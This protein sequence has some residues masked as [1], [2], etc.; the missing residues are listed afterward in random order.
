[1]RIGIG[2]LWQETNTL[3][4]CPTTR[5]D[6]EAMG[7][8]HGTEMIDDMA[9][10]NE[11]GG[12]IQS[13]RRWHP[14][15]EPIGLV[16]FSAWPSGIITCDA[17]NWMRC[18]LMKQLQS[19]MPL[20][21]V[22]LALHGSM[23]AEGHPDVEGDILEAVRQVIGNRIPLVATL[24]L[25]AQL[26]PAMLAATN[27]LVTY[28]SMPHIDIF[29]TGQRGTEVMRRILMEAVD[30]V[31]AYQRVPVVLPAERSNTE[32]D[33]GAASQRKRR[34]VE[35]E[36]S[37]GVLT[38]GVTVVQPWMDVPELCSAVVVTTDGNED[39]AAAHCAELATT[40]WDT[41]Y[42]YVPELVSVSHAVQRAHQN[43]ENGLSVLSDAAD[44]TTSGA[45]GDSVW[46]LEE[47]L[48]YEWKRPAIVTVVD[49]QTVERASGLDVS[50]QHEFTLG[51]KRDTRFGKSIANS[52]LINRRFQARFSMSGH[53]G[54]NLAIDMGPAV[55]LRR[56]NVYV[57]V[58]SKTGPHFAPELFRAAEMDPFQASLL[59][60]KSPCGFRAAYGER[61]SLILS[62][63]AP[64]CA[65]ADFHRSEFTNITRPL[66][67]WDDITSWSPDPTIFRAVD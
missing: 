18:E 15:P 61:A 2:Q 38:A 47:L 22:L 65:P 23:V 6:F 11:L 31:T 45:P 40:L 48:K 46:I 55:V 33:S 32:A 39:L 29:E 1:M 50:Q 9:N 13:L 67:P 53:I 44:A 7:V 62:V 19:N 34:L 52:F 24:D 8:S 49:P 57:F 64:G 66:W 27:V 63:Q 56:N 4:P 42:E 60:A 17:F 25:H 35:L 14:A 41:R 51:G 30:P 21:A 36:K 58:T 54:K 20:D 43:Q 37:E 3:N 16:R 12:F 59:V 26:T 10:T 28:H 5:A